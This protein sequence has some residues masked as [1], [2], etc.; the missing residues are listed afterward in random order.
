MFITYRSPRTGLARSVLV[1]R[2]S[3]CYQ[4]ITSLLQLATTMQVWVVA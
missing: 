4:T 2:T 1:Y 3:P